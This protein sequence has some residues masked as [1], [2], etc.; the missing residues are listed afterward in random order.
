VQDRPLASVSLNLDNLWTYLKTHGDPDWEAR[1]SFLRTFLPLA[2]EVCETAGLRVTFFVIGRDAERDED[3]GALRQIT[4]Y[5]HEVGNHSFEHEPW[6]Q[7]HSKAQLDEDVARAEASIL[8][9]TGQ[10]PV[11]FRGPAYSWSPAL[12]E[13]LE[14]RGYL[15]DASAMPTYVG[16]L[17]RAYYFRTSRLNARERALRS[18]LFGTFR[19]GRRPV[20]PY[21]WVLGE[22][23]ALLEIPI[24]TLPLVKTPFHLSYLLYL[25]RYSERLALA[26]LRLAVA[27]CRRAAIEPSFL[28][29][30]LDLLGAE[31]APEL[32]FF[33]GMDLPGARKRQFFLKVLATLREAFSLVTMG[34]HANTLRAR[35]NLTALSPASLAVMRSPR[36]AS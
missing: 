21:W 1:P 19:D 5:G 13:V 31:Q 11:G 15:Y 22:G 6:L 29:H 3:A 24:T 26:Y 27:A 12:L 34:A 2:L 28:L 32:K 23:R 35:W 30:P 7:E 20:E 14:E 17:A 33:P 36:V 4:R 9:A 8:R 18:A 25:S 16:P 10:R